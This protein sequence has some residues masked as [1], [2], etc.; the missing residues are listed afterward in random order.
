MAE[1]KTIPEGMKWFGVRLCVC[2]VIGFVIIGI[3]EGI[4]YYWLKHGSSNGAHSIPASIYKSEAWAAQ[5]EREWPKAEQ[6]Q[7]EPY[8]V[9]R[10]A[11]FSGKTINVDAAGIRK[12]W[13]TSC[14]EGAPTIWMFGDSALWGAGSPDWETIPSLLAKQYADSGQSVCVKNFGEK[15]WVST[16]E[17]IQLMLALKQAS[18]RPDL[19]IFYDGVS[20]SFI[21]YLSNVP[22][23]HTN[24]EDTKKIF[25]E[26]SDSS[27]G[28]GY[29]K[30]TN[31][32]QALVA[33]HSQLAAFATTGKPSDSGLSPAEMARRTLENYQ[34]N[35]TLV[36]MLANYYK[37]RCLF[38]WQPVLLAGEK[39]RSAEEEL[40]VRRVE[41]QLRPGASVLMQT[42]YDGAKNI[43]EPDFLYLGG[44]FTDD[45]KTMFVDFSH[46]SPEGNRIIAERIFQFAEHSES[47]AR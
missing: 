40:M 15:G 8:V 34:K 6:V 10:R 46:T 38:V 37:L 41:K 24:Y 20:D 23:S 19:V 14:Q 16:Q 44:V 28:F 30:R 3:G 12:T 13:Y 42:T 33:L 43:S 29:F 22:D 17:V 7:Y 9:W 31:T 25:E 36:E 26:A 27:S 2:I 18:S 47:L 32:Y 35:R 21:S 1:P 39:P 45:G 4:A 11:A 5:Y